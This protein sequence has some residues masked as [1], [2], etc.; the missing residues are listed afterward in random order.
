[1]TACQIRPQLNANEI[2][3]ISITSV[4]IGKYK[5]NKK[6]RDIKLIARRFEDIL[7]SLSSD[8]KNFSV[9]LKERIYNMLIT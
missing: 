1:M 5:V 2:F 4:L 3:I 9:N 6:R 8:R 7:S